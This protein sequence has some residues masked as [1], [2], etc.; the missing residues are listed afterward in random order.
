M[1]DINRIRVRAGLPEKNLSGKDAI[2]TELQKQK[3]LEFAGENIR[4]DDMV[5]WYGN[6]PAKLKAIMHER[7]TDSQHYELL[8]EE[9]ESGEKELVGY[10]PTDAF[11]IHKDLTILKL[12]SCTSRYLRQRWTLI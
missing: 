4:W 9:N 1:K 12:N 5:R 10:K 11:R 6:D 7:K 3:L 2:M 8:Y